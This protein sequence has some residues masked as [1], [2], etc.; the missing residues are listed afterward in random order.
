MKTWYD[1]QRQ[2]LIVTVL[3]S[4][5]LPP[6]TGGQYRQAQYSSIQYSPD[7]M[8]EHFPSTSKYIIAPGLWADKWLVFNISLKSEASVSCRNDLYLKT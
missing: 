6:R 2:E 4:V 7:L 8:S 5:D 3:S 1:R